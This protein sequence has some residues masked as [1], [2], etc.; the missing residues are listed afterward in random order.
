[1]PATF[2]PKFRSTPAALRPGFSSSKTTDFPQAI[3]FE[4]KMCLY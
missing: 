1:M 2:L 4:W 3:P